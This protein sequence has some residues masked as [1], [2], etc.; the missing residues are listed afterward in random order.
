MSK[1]IDRTSLHANTGG[2]AELANEVL[3]IF[4]GQIETWGR[5]LDAKSEPKVW[6]DAAHTIKGA[7]L[8]IGANPLAD[9]CKKAETAGRSEPPAGRVEAAVLLNDIRDIMLPTLEE[10]AKIQHEIMNSGAYRVS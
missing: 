6:A 2:D 7:A 4:K 8:G 1:R 3:E 10:V 9:V 5:M